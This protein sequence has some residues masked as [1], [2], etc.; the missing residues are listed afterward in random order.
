MSKMFK[1]A[2]VERKKEIMSIG[3]IIVIEGTDCSGKE[4]QS[5][6]LINK[7]SKEGNKTHYLCYPD[8]ET[9]TGKIIGLPYLGKSY[10]AEDFVKATKAK[11]I[12][13]LEARNKVVEEYQVDTISEAVAAELGHGWFPEGAPSVPGKIASLYYTADRAYNK[14]KID[15]Y[16][17]NG[18]NVILDRYVYSN[19]AHQGGKLEDPKARENMYEWLYDLEFNKM[20]LNEPDI[21]IFLHMPTEYAAL[22]KALRAEKLDE[23]EQ[24]GEYLKR[25]EQSYIEV[26]NKYGFITIECI[27]NQ[28]GPVSLENI[29]TPEEINEELF[30]IVKEKMEERK[31]TK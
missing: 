6:M 9:P 13:R 8:Y 18:D 14:H 21:K 10:I 4:T 27:R 26:A 12:E 30:K 19:F 25:A 7:L 2:Y 3:K 29:K 5:K 22:L 20:L 17:W 31:L 28:E 1:E 15:D 23:H 16:I 24:N 11:V